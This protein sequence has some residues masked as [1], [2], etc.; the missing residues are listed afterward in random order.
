MAGVGRPAEQDFV[1]LGTGVGQNLKD[2]GEYARLWAIAVE[3]LV[4]EGQLLWT[5]RGRATPV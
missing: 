4:E 1:V 3:S 5:H 2:S